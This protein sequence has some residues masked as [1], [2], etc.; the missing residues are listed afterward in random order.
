MS[1]NLIVV[2][3][4]TK[5]K[6]ISRFLGDDYRVVS[7][8]GHVMDLPVYRLGV[9]IENG[10]KP[11]YIVIK[12]KEK[13]IREIK[14]LIKESPKIYLA[15]DEDREGEAIGWH[16]MQAVEMDFR[17]EAVDRI[18]F[19]EITEEAILESLKTP[20]KI[21]LS[22]VDA[23]QARRLLDRIVGYKISPLLS[24]KIRK[25][26]SAGRVQSVGLEMIVNREKE[27]KKFK[28]KKYYS[29]EGQIEHEGKDIGV[30]LWGKDGVKFKKFQL[31]N[32]QHVEEIIRTCVGE[33]ISVADINRKEKKNS[34]LPPFITSTLQQDAF[35]RLGFIP[36]K[37]M[38]IAQQLYEGVELADGSS[39]GLI[40]YM[41]TDSVTIAKSAVESARKYIGLKLGD[42]YVPEKPNTYRSGKS[43]QEAHECIRPTS[44]FRLPEDVKN[45]LTPSQYRLY[46]L[47]W[48]R[49]IASQMKPA[50]IDHVQLDLVC[51]EYNF[52]A[53]G[54][55]IIFDG[56]MK[57]WQTSVSE[58]DIPMLAKGTA[59]SWKKLEHKEHE[60]KPPARFTS[61]TLISEL[62]KNGIGRPST[63]ATILKTLVGRKYITRES[64]SLVPQEIGIIVV[65]ALEK[66]FSGVIDREFTAKMENHLDEI[67][68]GRINW[69]TML[70]DFYEKFKIQY[71]SAMKNMKKIKDEATGKKCPK[72]GSPLV[73]R[74]GRN[75]KFMACSGYPK[76]K[77]TYTLDKND[78][79]VANRESD[80]KCPK[81]GAKL[82]IKKGRY[83]NF[84]ACSAYPACKTTFAI[85][86][87][88]Y[89]INI[90]LG[91]E[92]CPECGKDTVIRM[93]PRG[94]FLACTGFPKCRF[95]KGL[96]EL[97][98]KNG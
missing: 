71:Q 25:G 93:G 68:Q 37:T 47:I 46:R 92:K 41:R 18:V 9:D 52:R 48:E 76:C 84:M 77:Q 58:N 10:F 5:A 4:P 83:G 80:L 38:R 1:S 78:D 69:K 42:R 49:F 14:Q 23:Q 12:G 53:N 90:P 74:W 56:Y 88:G 59:F 40:T 45:T 70:E 36:E 28:P 34:P 86:Q 89:I 20:R 26:L 60:T 66:H 51:G 75:G 29:V 63:Y 97:E 21:D 82:I 64:G 94:R 15:M 6:I 39:T 73:I 8:M 98:A 50:S 33:P 67:A 31:D 19:H 16:L 62:E 32:L 55:K 95:S 65:E 61:A 13:I 7:S 11:E 35:N 24:K 17:S 54:Q 43:A 79:V 22:L 27:R 87:D 81:C 44:S 3:S 96:K 2:E 57:V 30:V 85:D 91:Y 72:C